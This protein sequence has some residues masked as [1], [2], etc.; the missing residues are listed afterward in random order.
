MQPGNLA[1]ALYLEG[2]SW[3][4]S[5]LGATYESVWRSNVLLLSRYREKRKRRTFEKTIRYESRKAY[6]EVRPRIK[7]RTGQCSGACGEDWALMLFRSQID[8]GPSSHVLWLRFAALIRPSS[9][10]PSWSRG[11][12][13]D[14]SV[15]LAR[16]ASRRARRWRP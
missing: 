9:R 2:R 15:T 16:A 12:P 10:A 4:Q 11:Y 14:A 6:A 13:A 1:C 7:V 3:I 5:L 8:G